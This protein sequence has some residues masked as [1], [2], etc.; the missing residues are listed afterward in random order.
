MAGITG[1]VI[2]QFVDVSAADGSTLAMGS[3]LVK[4]H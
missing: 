4:V 3:V 2:I 1:Y